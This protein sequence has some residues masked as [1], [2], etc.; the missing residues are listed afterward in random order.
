MVD[1]AYALSQEYENIATEVP[2]TNYPIIIAKQPLYK[3]K[4]R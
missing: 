3:I 4:N 2:Y 1:D